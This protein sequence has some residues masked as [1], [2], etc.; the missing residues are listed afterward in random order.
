MEVLDNP[1]VCVGYC[2]VGFID[3]QKRKVI[4]IKLIHSVISTTFCIERL[5][6]SDHAVV[7]E[8]TKAE[9]FPRFLFGHFYAWSFASNPLNGSRS[10]FY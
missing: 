2:V 4:W 8:Q 10:L 3:D 5:H 9:V 7:G 1:L 6:A